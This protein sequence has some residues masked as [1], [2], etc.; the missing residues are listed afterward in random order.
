MILLL[1]QTLLTC[2]GVSYTNTVLKRM[3]ADV[4]NAKAD[5]GNIRG[6]N[7]MMKKSYALTLTTAGIYY[8]GAL[9][10]YIGSGG[11]KTLADRD[12]EDV[13]KNIIKSGM[14]LTG[15]YGLVDS[16]FQAL[17]R[18]SVA[19]GVASFVSPVG[20][21]TIK[22]VTRAKKDGVGGVVSGAVP[23]LNSEQ[24]GDLAD[25]VNDLIDDIIN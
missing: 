9:K 19:E 4:K 5:G 3:Y 7:E 6:L 25:G 11:E 16:L 12:E 8:N 14:A 21:S 20:S 23:V 1:S 18:R 13:Q 24:R 22:Q 15:N 10:E 2:L 17:D